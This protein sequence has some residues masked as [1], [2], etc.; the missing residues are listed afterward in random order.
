MGEAPFPHHAASCRATVVE[1]GGPVEA[2]EPV[3]CAEEVSSVSSTSTTGISTTSATRGRPAPVT[4]WEPRLSACVPLPVPPLHR[5]QPM[6]SGRHLTVESLLTGEL[7]S[8]VPEGFRS[9]QFSQFIAI[10]GT[11]L[12]AAVRSYVLKVPKVCTRTPHVVTRS[13]ENAVRRRTTTGIDRTAH[14]P[15]IA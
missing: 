7:S 2:L 12:S 10:Y 13:P 3:A 14:C 6:R 1:Q 4:D 11:Y 5:A 9:A 15:W 8:F